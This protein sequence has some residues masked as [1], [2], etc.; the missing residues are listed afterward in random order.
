MKHRKPKRYVDFPTYNRIKEMS[1]LS[2]KEV[3]YKLGL[4]PHTVARVRYQIYLEQ[5]R[6]SNQ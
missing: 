6:K 5:V 2:D 1:E 3:G 4:D